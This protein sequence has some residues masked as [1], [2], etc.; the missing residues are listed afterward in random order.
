MGATCQRSASEE[1][2]MRLRLGPVA[3]ALFAVLSN[4]PSH[5]QARMSTADSSA[6]AREL[7]VWNALQK[8]DS[9]AAF[10]KLVGNSPRLNLVSPDGLTQ[11]SASELG[12]LITTRC[13]RRKNQLDS[14]HVERV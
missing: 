2:V 4:R 1:L 5:A 12:K 3:A 6:V 11:M 8:K 7:A 14:A 9:G 10:V 13:E